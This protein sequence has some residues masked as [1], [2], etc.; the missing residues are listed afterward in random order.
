LPAALFAQADNL[1]GAG[2]AYARTDRLVSATVF[3]W[4]GPTDGQLSGPWRPVEGRANWTGETPFWQTQIK[5]MMSANIDTL[6]VHLF[7]SGVHEQRR[8]NLFKALGQMRAAGYEVPKVVPFLDPP[9]TWFDTHID[10][11]TT[12]GSRPDLSSS[13]MCFRS[14]LDTEP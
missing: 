5:Q 7:D 8:I 2:R 6:Y 14:S 10:V 11:A 13:S 9:L 4:F 1:A 3:H 12:A